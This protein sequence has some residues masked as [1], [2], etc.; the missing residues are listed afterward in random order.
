MVCC[1]QREYPPSSGN[2]A[3]F[4][5][6]AFWLREG[7]N[8][9]R[10]DFRIKGFAGLAG[11][12]ARPRGHWETRRGI[13][14]DRRGVG[15][16]RRGI[17]HARRPIGGRIAHRLCHLGSIARKGSSED[18][19]FGSIQRVF[20]SNRDVLHPALL[21]PVLRGLVRIGRARRVVAVNPSFTRSDPRRSRGG[22][23]RGRRWSHRLAGS[24]PA[25]RRKGGRGQCRCR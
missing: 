14:R 3:M 4:G 2:L 10:Q 21:A 5:W 12:G 11:L 18:R 23:F 20:K 15:R 9:F 13:G 16:D 7:V 1:W 17:G 24:F 8:L 25:M 6:G 22:V 19:N